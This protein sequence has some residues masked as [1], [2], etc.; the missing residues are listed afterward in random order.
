VTEAARRRGETV[1]G[2][3]IETESNDSAKAYGVH[4]NPKKSEKVT[5]APKDKVIVI[6]ED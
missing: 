3:R 6:A 5:F 1:L 4:T 2:Y